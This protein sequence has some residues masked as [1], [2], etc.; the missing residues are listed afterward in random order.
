PS[1]DGGDA[2]ADSQ[3]GGDGGVFGDGGPVARQ[4]SVRGVSKI[5]VDPAQDVVLPFPTGAG[6]G[7]VAWVVLSSDSN[8]NAVTPPAAF[9]LIG[10]DPPACGPRGPAV[11]VFMHVMTANEPSQ[12]TFRYSANTTVAA[13]LLSLDGLSTAPTAVLNSALQRVVSNPYDAPT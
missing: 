7:D 5:F 6:A 12:Y 11:N 4:V 1:A 8:T 10:R 9:E 2:S 13:L 3:N